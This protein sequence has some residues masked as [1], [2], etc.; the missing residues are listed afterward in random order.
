MN[1]PIKLAVI[2]A[3]GAGKTTL[4]AGYAAV[5]PSVGGT[6]DTSRGFF[7]KQFAAWDKRTWPDPTK[8]EKTIN[9]RIGR[10][11]R[12]DAIVSFAEYMGESFSGNKDSSYLE[13]IV[14]TP[15]AALLLVNPR[16]PD[17]VDPKKRAGLESDTKKV[18]DYL[19]EKSGDRPADKRIALALVWTASDTAAAQSDEFW[20][21]SKRIFDYVGDRLPCK[22]FPVTLFGPMTNEA[23]PPG[24]PTDPDRNTA[25]KPFEWALEIVESRRRAAWRK[26]VLRRTLQGVGTVLLAALVAVVIQNVCEDARRDSLQARFDLFKKAPADNAD[27]QSLKNW[28]TDWT[29]ATN[30]AT[31]RTSADLVRLGDQFESSLPDWQRLQLGKESEAIV[32]NLNR[33]GF[34][35]PLPQ[36]IVANFQKWYRTAKR[37]EESRPH[38]YPTIR[39]SDFAP[40]RDKLSTA[41]QAAKDRFKNALSPEEAISGTLIESVWKSILDPEEYE[42]FKES[43]QGPVREEMTK[44]AQMEIDA[45]NSI[46]GDPA[47]VL[48]HCRS[49]STKHQS[50]PDKEMVV[51]AAISLVG[52]WLFGF[53]EQSRRM[54]SPEGAIRKNEASGFSNEFDKF[55]LLCKEA[56]TGFW[57]AYATRWPIALGRE[58]AGQPWFNDAMKTTDA[59]PQTFT[60]SKVEVVWLVDWDAWNKL[61][62]NFDGFRISFDVF[63]RGRAADAK[64][65][66]G[67]KKST[68]TKDCQLK[69]KEAKKKSLP[70]T[71]PIWNTP[72]PKIVGLGEE[73][74]VKLNVHDSLSGTFCWTADSDLSHGLTF[75]TTDQGE[76]QGL[77][78]DGAVETTGM[79]HFTKHSGDKAKLKFRFYVSLEGRSLESMIAEFQ[80]RERAK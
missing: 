29:T 75:K 8:D 39:E 73:V 5:R 27:P 51:G 74:Y 37:L 35:F 55:R 58:C 46:R 45:L 40:I 65:I 24:R 62:A 23:V 71:V 22:E 44:E 64:L 1:R 78:P 7:E 41:R 76:L 16:M 13:R 48:Q 53:S 14:G 49:W 32:D 26:N 15:D 43:I 18:I 70:M 6:D 21:F 4:V 59:F 10:N 50:N 38:D 9:F 42:A 2:G 31:E 68:A 57:D 67:P 77:G 47:G 52:K 69:R 20:T 11:G 61:H 63:K 19:I 79:F 80:A 72:T 3:Q 17:F 12:D 56:K 36:P 28:K 54:P 25:P 33:E 34:T 60:L 30:R 66:E